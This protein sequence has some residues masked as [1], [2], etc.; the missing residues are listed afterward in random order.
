MFTPT[1]TASIGSM[2]AGFTAVAAVWGAGG[3]AAATTAASAPHLITSESTTAPWYAV[4][5]EAL[6]G[7][8]P[9]AYLVRHQERVMDLVEQYHPVARAED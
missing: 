7:L 2:L 5:N 9:N 3:P 1:R 8:T 4:P 6:G